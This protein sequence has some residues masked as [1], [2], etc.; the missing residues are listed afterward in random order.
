M[1]DASNRRVDAIQLD[2]CCRLSA[3]DVAALPVD[4][5]TQRW[6]LKLVLRLLCLVAGRS[7][8]R[9]RSHRHGAG[10]RGRV[11]ARCV[12]A[13]C[14]PRR[15]SANV[16]P[17]SNR[18]NGSRDPT[19]ADVIDRSTSSSSSSSSSSSLSSFSSFQVHQRLTGVDVFSS[20]LVASQP[21]LPNAAI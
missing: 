21:T 12:A 16:A 9:G 6:R 19:L 2:F 18:S 11:A 17:G 4:T 7:R 13:P 8:S 3:D 15:A 10:A 20:L 1:V 14:S 5:V